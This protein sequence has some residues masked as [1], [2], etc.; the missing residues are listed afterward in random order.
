MQELCP[1]CNCN[2]LLSWCTEDG[3]GNDSRANSKQV[4]LINFFS[5]SVADLSLQVYCCLSIFLSS[6]GNTLISPKCCHYGLEY[7]WCSRAPTEERSC[8]KNICKWQR[9][10][11]NFDMSS[12]QFFLYLK[13]N[14]VLELC[15]LGAVQTAV[16]SGSAV[17]EQAA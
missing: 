7:L 14:K 5:L 1:I 10:Q 6:L 9:S 8:R 12:C 2:Y 15:S 4:L 13:A 17:E 3:E 11:S 16:Y